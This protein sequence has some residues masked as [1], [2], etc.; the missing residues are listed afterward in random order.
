[1][2]NDLSFKPEN[3]VRKQTEFDEIFR[4]GKKVS[5]K[6]LFA[7]ILKHG[8]QPRIGFVISKK[9]RNA[10]QRNRLR[11]QIKEIFRN[12]KNMFDGTSVIIGAKREVNALEYGELE[13]DMTM[14]LKRAGCLKK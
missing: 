7:Y 13:N 14:I 4:S 6:Y 2:P 10:A 3:R 1:M 11:R 8:K 12:N 5:G 9:N